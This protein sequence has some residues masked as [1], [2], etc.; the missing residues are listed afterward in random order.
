M[1]TTWPTVSVYHVCEDGEGFINYVVGVCFAIMTGL[2]YIILLIIR[3]L[4]KEINNLTQNI[5]T[6][7]FIDL[8]MMYCFL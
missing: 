3:L 1:V 2:L 5:T 6:K 8:K 4:T 7:T